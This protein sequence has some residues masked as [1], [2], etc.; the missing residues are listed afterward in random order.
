MNL[1]EIMPERN[2]FVD[3]PWVIQKIEDECV[4]SSFDCVDDDLNEYFREDAL[5]HK[6]E[7]LT[8][9]YSLQEAS[10][11]I[12]VPLALFDL[13]NDS[14][15]LKKYKEIVDLDPTKQYPFLPAVKITRF[16]VTKELHGLNLGSHTLNLIKKLFLTDNRTGCRLITV[17]AYNSDKVLAFYAKNGFQPF[18]NKD[19]ERQ[20]RSLFFDLKRLDL[21]M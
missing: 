5:P 15:H 18:N 4:M 3:G 21:C 17:D 16:G 1:S 9:T 10:D 20:T 14:V 8:Q 2:V 6:K 7:L 12:S 19:C 11:E 13:C